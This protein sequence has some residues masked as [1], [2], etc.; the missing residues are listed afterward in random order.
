MVLRSLATGVN[1]WEVA[2]RH[3]T[4]E[5]LVPKK[6]LLIPLYS[7]EELFQIASLMARILFKQQ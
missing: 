4:I 5:C 7:G 2:F 6:R 1:E 3:A